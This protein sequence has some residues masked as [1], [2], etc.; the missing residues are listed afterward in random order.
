MAFGDYEITWPGS[1]TKQ[2]VR[3]LPLDRSVEITE[4]REGYRS[5]E[6]GP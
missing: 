1:G 2:T 5:L 4:A 6:P 3:G